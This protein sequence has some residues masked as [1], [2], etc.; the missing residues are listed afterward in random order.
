MKTLVL[1]LGNDLLADDAVGILAAHE[2]Q[3]QLQGRADVVASALHGLALL[4]LF[5]GY[6]RAI[7]I[8]AIQTGKHPPGSIIEISAADLSHVYA[9]SPHYAGLPEMLDLAKQ[10]GLPF[11]HDLT[12]FAIEVADIHTVGGPMT[13]AVRQAIRDLCRRVRQA[14]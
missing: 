2:L 8:D 9:P 13:P 1:G 6:D 7:I 11:P 10:L 3:T 4:D 5:I 14:L 12:I